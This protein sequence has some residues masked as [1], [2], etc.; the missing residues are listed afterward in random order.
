MPVLD[1]DSSENQKLKV[2]I[3]NCLV[4]SLFWHLIAA[5]FSIGYHQADEHFQVLEFASWKMGTTPIQSLPWEF[6]ARIRPALQPLF[7]VFVQKYCVP[8]ANPFQVSFLLRLFSGLSGFGALVFILLINLKI[9]EGYESKRFLILITTFLWFVPYVHVHF[10]SESISGSLFFFG[11]G[12]I[13]LGNNQSKNHLLALGGFLIG[14]SFVCRFQTVFMIFGLALWCIF[15]AKMNWKALFMIG[16]PVLIAIAIGVL[17]DKWF[18]GEWVFTSWNYFKINVI[19]GKAS[20]FG[21]SP[22]YAYFTWNFADLIPPFSILIIAGVIYSL[23][24]YR[25]NI[26]SLTIIPFLLAH[27]FVAHK[28]ARFLFPMIGAVPILI[29][30][31]YK[32]FIPKYFKAI[33]PRT[34]SLNIYF[35]LSFIMMAISCL[36]PASDRAGLYENLYEHYNGKRAT[37]LC[38]K[39]NPYNSF[40][41]N[42][43]FRPKDIS[44]VD[45]LGIKGIDSVLKIKGREP[46]PVL[47]SNLNDANVFASQHPEAKIVY[48]SFPGW[49]VNFN[50]FNWLSRTKLWVLFEV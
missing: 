40:E 1:L 16:F 48:S 5:W 43:Y 3:R 14:L 23:V 20:Y 11:L 22:W 31:A 8:W 41:K 32:D 46:R 39:D 24:K 49:A 38:E 45:S 17:I 7:V 25:T 10:S 12:C 19:E 26:F 4:F 35:G 50:Y 6:A 15:I 2:L 44:I 18:Y 47:F 9:I 29:A 30:L 33:K 28:E 21:T 13:L 34:I 42:Y 37:L 36:K 27:L